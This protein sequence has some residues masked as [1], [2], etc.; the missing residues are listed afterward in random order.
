MSRENTIL[1]A[2]QSSAEAQSA[3]AALQQAGIPRDDIYLETKANQAAEGRHESHEG[4]FTGWVKSLFSED[5]HVDRSR[6]ESAL[7]R[8]TSLLRVDVP[9]EEIAA[10]EEILNRYSPVDVHAES[11]T[12]S[13][14]SS[15]SNT[16]AIPV[17]KEEIQVG[18]REVLRGGVRVY[19]R[20]TEQPV[21][22]S[23]RLREEHV[24]VDRQPV[25]RAATAADLSNA[26]EQVIEVQEFAEEPVIAKQARV[27]EEVR[28]GKDVSERTENVRGSVRNTEVKV[29]PISGTPE[30]AT[31]AVP[32]TSENS[33]FRADYQQRYAATGDAYDTYLPAY[34]YGHSMASDP[35]YQGRSFEESEADLRADYGRRYPDGTWERTKDAVRVGWERMTGKPV[36]AGRY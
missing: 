6:Y 1:A 29:E 16:S 27:V 36:G 33:D 10:V 32:V 25:N 5:D 7:Q 9:E 26:R 31:N 2:Y 11:A 14:V 24:R 18:K 23:I 34:Q 35:R 22:N 28:I 30:R 17:V 19:S 3:A 21:E 20:L 8:G 13:K 15:G 12:A 4:G